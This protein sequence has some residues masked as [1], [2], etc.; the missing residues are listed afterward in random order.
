MIPKRQTKFNN[1]LF[2][3]SNNNKSI[4]QQG[5]EVTIEDIES[6]KYIKKI[7]DGYDFVDAEEAL[8][9]DFESMELN[10]QQLD[11]EFD[12]ARAEEKEAEYRKQQEEEKED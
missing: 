12:Y 9:D 10:T 1:M 8:D 6:G 4:T 7:A 11:A 3:F 2:E 5:Q